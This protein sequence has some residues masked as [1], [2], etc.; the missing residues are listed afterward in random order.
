M[1]QLPFVYHTYPHW[2]NHTCHTHTFLHILSLILIPLTHIATHIHTN[3]H[4][5]TCIVTDCI[6]TGTPHT[7]PHNSHYHSQFT[8]IHKCTHTEAVTDSMYDHIDWSSLRLTFIPSHPP[9]HWYTCSD[10]PTCPQNH[11][12]INHWFSLDTFWTAMYSYPDSHMDTLPLTYTH[13]E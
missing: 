6:Y 4:I 10:W 7:G 12:C 9:L 3:L 1:H 13:W 2:H 5:V 11:C 8:K